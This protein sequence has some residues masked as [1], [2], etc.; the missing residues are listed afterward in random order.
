MFLCGNSGKR[1]EW[2]EGL[3]MAGG[4][5]GAPRKKLAEALSGED[6]VSPSLEVGEVPPDT[7]R[8]WGRTWATG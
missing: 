5:A 6:P 8:D 4:G 1:R 2:V 7:P 3:E